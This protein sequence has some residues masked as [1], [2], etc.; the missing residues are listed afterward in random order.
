MSPPVV[1]LC[2][3]MGHILAGFGLL[4]RPIETVG[5]NLPALPDGVNNSIDESRGFFPSMEKA[6][7][8]SAW[9]RLRRINPGG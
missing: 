3:R 7:L 1:R 5:A 2:W 6:R 9:A 4:V 8:V